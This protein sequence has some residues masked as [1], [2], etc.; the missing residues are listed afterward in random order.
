MHSWCCSKKKKKKFKKVGLFLNWRVRPKK[1]ILLKS[2]N[3]RLG[4][5]VTGFLKIIMI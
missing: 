2:L 5:L 1:S 4:I 3:I